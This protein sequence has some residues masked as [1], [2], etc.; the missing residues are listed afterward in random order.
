MRIFEKN[1][2]NVSRTARDFRTSRMVV[3]KIAN[4]Y[5]KEGEEG[6]LDK[7][8]KPKSHPNQSSKHYECLVASYRRKTNY[9]KDRL[10][11]IIKTE[12]GINIPPSTIR[13]I[14]RRLGLS[15]V[16]K[17]RSKSFRQTSFYNYEALYPLQFWQIDLKELLDLKALPKNVYE[18]IL[19]LKLPNY[20]FTA[21][22]VIIRTKFIMYGYEKSFLNGLDFMLFLANWLR[23]FGI[24]HKLYMQKDNGQEFGGSSP[25]KL[26]YIQEKYFDPINVLALNIPKGESQFNGYVERTHR[27]DDEEFYIPQLSDHFFAAPALILD[28][29]SV[30]RYA[31]HNEHDHQNHYNIQQQYNTKN[32]SALKHDIISKNHIATISQISNLHGNDL[33][34]HYQK[35]ASSKSYLKSY[36]HFLHFFH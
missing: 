15:K 35:S 6:F 3:R 4:R 12:H 24:R 22:D 13:N 34:D 31:L 2:H 28:E 9:G 25:R 5:K 33:S 11:E 18:Y 32:N 19:K 1:K 8:K 16:K 36:S 7:S 14:L 29:P 26:Q 17:R 21:I 30:L 27:T 10:S 20:Q 23:A